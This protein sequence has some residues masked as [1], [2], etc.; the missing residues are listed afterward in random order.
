MKEMEKNKS[1]MSILQVTVGSTT[2]VY[3]LIAENNDAENNDG[4]NKDNIPAIFEFPEV[5]NFLDP[6]THIET[7][8]NMNQALKVE[9][10][11]T[12][13]LKEEIL[14]NCQGSLFL[15]RKTIQSSCN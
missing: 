9:D 4:E 3:N 5:S 6:E 1:E 7:I 2:I 10:M 15:K 12:C 8:I 14:P 13:L 11:S